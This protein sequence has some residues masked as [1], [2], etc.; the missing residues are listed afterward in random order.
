MGPLEDR[1]GCCGKRSV[2]VLALPPL[3]V[4]ISTRM[5]ANSGATTID[6]RPWSTTPA[7]LLK[8]GNALFLSFERPE[9]AEDIHGWNPVGGAV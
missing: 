5:T 9:N 1:T 6:A 3:A 4:P 2:A 8:V 7:F